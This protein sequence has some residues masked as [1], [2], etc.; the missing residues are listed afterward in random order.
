MRE[1]ICGKNSVQDALDNNLPIKVI[2]TSRKNELNNIQGRNVQ[3][4]DKRSLDKMTSENHQGFIAELKEFNYFSFDEILKDK[5]EKI[6]ILD[7]VQ[8]P[9]NLGAIL[10]SANAAGVKHIVIPKDRAAKVTPSA[11]K[12][13]SGGYVGIKVIR[14]NS[15][16]DV[17]TKLKKNSFWIYASALDEKASELNETNFNYPMALVVGNEE[18]GVSNTILKHSDQNVYIN[19]KGTVQSLNVSVAAGIFLFKI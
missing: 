16:I 14:V 9:R 8:D 11:L 12:V 2:Y 17:I 3:V 15:L 4:V 5:P 13:S 18:K 10:R 6:L 7:H 19:M 1:F